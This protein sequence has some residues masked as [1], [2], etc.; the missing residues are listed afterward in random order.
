MTPMDTL[1]EKIGRSLCFMRGGCGIMQCDIQ[2]KC[3]SAEPN[4]LSEADIIL[5]LLPPVS[6]LEGL[7]A[8]ELVAV[9]RSIAV[10]A[11]GESW[12]AARFGYDPTLS[13]AKPPGDER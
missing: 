3:T 6:V 13:A 7:I 5:S 4:G 1:R 2:R 8:G 9:P 12:V 10:E 11:L